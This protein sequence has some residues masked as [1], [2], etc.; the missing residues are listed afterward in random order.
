MPADSTAA[1][2]ERSQT[3]LLNQSQVVAMTKPRP[4]FYTAGT[5]AKM[6]SACQKFDVVRT[7]SST[8]PNV[9][10][11]MNSRRRRDAMPHASYKSHCAL[12]FSP[13]KNI[14][15]FPNWKY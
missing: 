7:S 9:E 13:P 8:G 6:R 1:L 11:W 10:P 3:T 14:C 15:P 2:Y 4:L 5:S 12:R